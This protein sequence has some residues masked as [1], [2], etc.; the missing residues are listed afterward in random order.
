[1][2]RQW[3]RQQDGWVL[4]PAPTLTRSTHNGIAPSLGF[5]WA[6]T[7]IMMLSF[8]CRLL[9]AIQ[10]KRGKQ[11]LTIFIHSIFPAGF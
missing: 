4:L 7:K 1:M 6:E 3:D 2:A 8:L 10:T 5:L 9:L 11:E